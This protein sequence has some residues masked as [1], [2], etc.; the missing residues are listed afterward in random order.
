LIEKVD[1]SRTNVRKFGYLFGG[2]CL[3]AS[4]YMM[5]RGNPAWIWAACGALVFAAGGAFCYPLMKHVYTIWMLFAFAL[6]WINTRVLLGVFFYLVMT[7]IGF[8]IRLRGKDLL[9]E[10]IDKHAVTYWIKRE[11]KPFD[12]KR[13]ERMF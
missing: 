2:I 8:F 7:P 13:L 10:T 1:A 11:R 9:D 12:R 5:Y 4:V 3:A 6:G